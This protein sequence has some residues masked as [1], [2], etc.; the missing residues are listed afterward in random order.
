MESEGVVV[1]GQFDGK[2]VD[3]HPARQ[4][5]LFAFIP[6]YSLGFCFGSFLGFSLTLRIGVLVFCDGFAPVEKFC[7]AAGTAEEVVP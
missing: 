3:G 7:S 5:F 6:A 2:R 1:F 4:G